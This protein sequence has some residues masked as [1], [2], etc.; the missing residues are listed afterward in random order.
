M[1]YVQRRLELNAAAGRIERP[2]WLRTV[3]DRGV[4]NVPQ[5]EAGG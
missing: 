2:E 4:L 1:T 5:A 3:T